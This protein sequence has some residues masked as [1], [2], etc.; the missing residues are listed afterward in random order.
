[1][2]PSFTIGIEEEYQTI[3]PT[4]FDLRSHINAEIISKGKRQLDERIK[5]QIGDTVPHKAAYDFITQNYTDQWLEWAPAEEGWTSGL[6]ERVD[7]VPP[8]WTHRIDMV[9]ARTASGGPLGVDRGEVTGRELSDRDAATGLWPSDH[10]G[11]V[12]RLR[13]L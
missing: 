8:S 1:M 3:D 13:G 4:S 12:L 5:T 9:F 10:A 11:V 7:E 6:N 2:R